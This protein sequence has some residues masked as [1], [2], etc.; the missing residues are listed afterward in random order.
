MRTPDPTVED[1]LRAFILTVFYL[2]D[3]SRLTNDTSLIDSGIVDSTGMLDIILFVES[4]FGIT[5]LDHETTPE[6]FETI[7]RVA[8]FIEGKTGS[9]AE[10]DPS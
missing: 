4:E 7:A 10:P 8:T 9:S 3:P 5:V 6:N 1:R 2:T